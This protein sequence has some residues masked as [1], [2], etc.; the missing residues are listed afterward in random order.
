MICARAQR[1]AFSYASRPWSA[2]AVGG[3]VPT[4]LLYNH[5][6]E[7]TGQPNFFVMKTLSVLTL[8]AALIFIGC[9]DSSPS[10]SQEI[11]AI[12]PKQEEKPHFE[13]LFYARVNDGQVWYFIDRTGKR[14]TWEP[15]QETLDFSEGLAAVKK[16][17][18]W[19][20]IDPTEKVVIPFRYTHARSFFHG[21]AR[22]RLD[23]NFVYINKLGKTGQPASPDTT[24]L[25]PEFSEGLKSF[26]A[27]VDPKKGQF[28][29]DGRVVGYINE[30]GYI[31]IPATFEAGG[32]FAFGLAPAQ[33]LGEATEKQKQLEKVLSE[34]EQGDDYLLRKYST[35]TEFITPGLV[36]YIDVNGSWIIQPKFKDA[37][38]FHCVDK[39]DEYTPAPL[40][41]GKDFVYGKDAE[42][43]LKHDDQIGSCITNNLRIRE[44]GDMNSPAIGA[45]SIGDQVKILGER[46]ADSISVEINGKETKGVF[47]KVETMKGKTGW[48]FSGGIKQ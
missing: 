24:I 15:Y 20:Y 45:L 30:K 36:G 32:E 44:K 9:K 5:L 38:E 12:P 42:E 22:V 47:L 27:R 3:F 39:C 26:S 48:V 21:V 6:S 43:L 33:L 2:S 19:G 29:A 28:S 34:K 1:G 11:T 16:N 7:G 46:T 18:R 31:V 40:P 8:L 23:D 14:C 25:K 13:N 17:G 35:N 10:T 41:E 37:Y 4:L